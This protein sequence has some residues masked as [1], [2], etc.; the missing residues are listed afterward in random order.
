MG[1]FTEKE[2]DKTTVCGALFRLSEEQNGGGWGCFL[3]F[4]L[5]LRK[6]KDMTVSGAVF[7]LSVFL[8]MADGG[9]SRHRSVR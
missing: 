1:S 8:R 4:C 2:K 9:W 6:G 3:Y 5:F 7:H